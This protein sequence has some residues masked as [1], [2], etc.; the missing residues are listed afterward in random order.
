MDLLLFDNSSNSSKLRNISD[1]LLNINNK[2][3]LYYIVFIG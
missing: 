1:Y 2:N 3:S